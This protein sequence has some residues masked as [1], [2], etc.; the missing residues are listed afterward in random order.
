[1]TIALEVTLKPLM[2]YLKVTF[3]CL[4]L[5][6][7]FKSQIGKTLMFF[8]FFFFLTN[9]LVYI[10]NLK[11]MTSINVLL[12]SFKKKKFGICKLWKGE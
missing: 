4:T 8:S 11:K 6:V 9:N 2:W 1:M 12:P 5:T 10:H 3:I 7:P